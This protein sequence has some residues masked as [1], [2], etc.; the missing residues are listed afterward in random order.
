[1]VIRGVFIV[2][3]LPPITT[4]GIKSAKYRCFRGIFGRKLR[5]YLAKTLL[6]RFNTM[7]FQSFFAILLVKKGRKIRSDAVKDTSRRSKSCVLMQ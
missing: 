6:F 7:L 5:R 3:L 4:F 2:T 1:M